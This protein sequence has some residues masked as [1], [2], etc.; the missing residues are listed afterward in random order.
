MSDLHRPRI[1]RGIFAALCVLL[2]FLLVAQACKKQSQ[3]TKGITLTLIDQSWVDKDYQL[4]VKQGNA[5]F[6]K[7]SGIRVEQ[8]PAPEAAVEQLDLWRKLLESGARTP[9]VYSIDV[10]WPGILADNLIDLKSYMP[11]EDIKMLLPALVANGTVNGRL[12]SLPTDVNEGVLFYRVDLLKQY[13]FHGPPQ[14]WEELESMAKRIQAGERAKG[15]K[16]FWGFVWQGAAS[17]ALTCNA[18]EWQA[19]EGGGTILDGNGKV[20]INNP[21]AVRAWE[22]AAR[23]VG[24]ISPPAVVEHKEWDSLNL[25][26]AGH[27]AFMRNWTGS[28]RTV[29]ASESPTRYQSEIAPLPGGEAGRASMI[30]GTGYGVSRHSLHPQQA[31]AFVHFLASRATQLQRSHIVNEGPTIAELYIDPELL[32][33]NPQF[34]LMLDILRKYAVFRPS[35]PAGK[36]YPE[37]SR[38]YFEAVHT[39]LTHKKPAAQAASELERDL[40]AMLKTSADSQVPVH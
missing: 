21:A 1:R 12:V 17:E 26:Q 37:V 8:L 40:R 29:K 9:D 6:T 10:I 35:T 22:R 33:A 25:W 24:T 34:P 2:L 36:M 18:L 32:K 23:W 11:E 3:T 20:T 16:N 15:D 39:V 7:Q 38:A 30:G 31:A 14:T 27:A 4:Q 28:Y 19:S 13:G 5:D